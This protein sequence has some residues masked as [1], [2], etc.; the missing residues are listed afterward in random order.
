[1]DV[2]GAAVLRQRIELHQ[3]WRSARSVRE[4]RQCA[5]DPDSHLLAEVRGNERHYVDGS[6]KLLVN[7]RWQWRLV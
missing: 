2:D 5:A 3:H 1:M 7:G 4:G 6:V